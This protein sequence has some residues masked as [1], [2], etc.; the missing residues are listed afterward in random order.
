ML[1][2]CLSAPGDPTALT[3]DSVTVTATGQALGVGDASLPSCFG[4]LS[5]WHLWKALLSH[6]WHTETLSFLC[7]CFLTLLLL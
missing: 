1:F 5:K 7:I 3:P 6:V 4:S 2:H